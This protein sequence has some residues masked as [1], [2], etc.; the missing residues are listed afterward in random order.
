MD[1]RLSVFGKFLFAKVKVD[2]GAFAKGLIV[3]CA[4]DE[5]ADGWVLGREGGKK[6]DEAFSRQGFETDP[7]AF[8]IRAIA[9]SLANT[10]FL[11]EFGDI[12]VDADSVDRL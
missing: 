5:C 10:R 8:S 12:F 6:R 11:L 2:E 9:E 3:V 7:H 4:E 1:C